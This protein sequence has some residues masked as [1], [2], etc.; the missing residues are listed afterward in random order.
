MDARKHRI[1]SLDSASRALNALCFWCV[2]LC[3]NI[4]LETDTGRRRADQSCS[5]DPLGLDMRNRK[6]A[7]V[8]V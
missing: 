6:N 5:A 4:L 2:S 8:C 1:A 3:E 7:T